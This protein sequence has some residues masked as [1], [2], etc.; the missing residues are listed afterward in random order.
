MV[1]KNVSCVY[2]LTYLSL[3]SRRHDE[4]ALKSEDCKP[5][6]LPLYILPDCMKGAKPL[7]ASWNPYSA[8]DI[9]TQILRDFH[10]VR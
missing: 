2:K 8:G 5:V 3:C 6:H 1:I 7:I 10:P 4:L 9:S